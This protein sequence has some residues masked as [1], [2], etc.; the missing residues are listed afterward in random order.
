MD[1]LLPKVTKL[2]PD[3]VVKLDELPDV[4]ETDEDPN[5][6]IFEDSD[7]LLTK[8][9]IRYLNGME[10]GLTDKEMARRTGV[11]P[12][13][14]SNWKSGD[15]PRA[16]M[17][18]Q[19]YENRLNSFRRAAVEVINL[20]DKLREELRPKAFKRLE[21]LLSI[22]IHVKSP[23]GQMTAQL[24]AIKEV[25]EATGDL[26]KDASSIALN[27]LVAERVQAGVE[28]RPAWLGDPGE[29]KAV[30]APAS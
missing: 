8:S 10:P 19:A 17:F 11:N 16:K 5:A 18:L 3:E 14:V 22:P 27:I 24:N 1:D 13:T 25:L 20:D 30:A 29:P 21:E 2:R 4:E 28:Y 23:S 7:G 6:P 15:S 26:K 12:A 9:Q